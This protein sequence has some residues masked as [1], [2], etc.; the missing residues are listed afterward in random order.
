[1]AQPVTPVKRTQGAAITVASKNG[2]PYPITH[3]P[4]LFAFN[5]NDWPDSQAHQACHTGRNQD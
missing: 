4:F 1:M 3:T 2:L 5:L